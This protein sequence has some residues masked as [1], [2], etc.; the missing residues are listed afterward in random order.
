MDELESDNQHNLVMKEDDNLALD[1]LAPEEQQQVTE[2][3]DQEEEQQANLLEEE[4][5]VVAV[6]D[7]VEAS[8]DPPVPSD[9]PYHGNDN[10]V[11]VEAS[12]EPV[13]TL[14]TDE[15]I[16]IAI[17]KKEKSRRRDEMRI[18]LCKH[19]GNHPE[20]DY[21]FSEIHQIFADVGFSYKN[22]ALLDEFFQDH[23]ELKVGLRTNNTKEDKIIAVIHYRLSNSRDPC[24]NTKE[25]CNRV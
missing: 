9:D 7:K 14:L 6:G 24:K 13:P 18:N 15:Q 22:L 17:R 21:K 1:R 12:D 5:R 8:N 25:S 19:Q 23:P 20:N 2:E 3:H 4:E 16:E 10:E 11:A